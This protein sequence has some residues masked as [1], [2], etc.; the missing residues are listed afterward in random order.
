MKILFM[1]CDE[2]LAP[3]WARVYRPG[4]DPDIAVNRSTFERDAVPEVVA[5]YP[6]LILDHSYFP[7]PIL[8]RCRDLKHIVY[9]GTGVASYVDLAAAERLGIA[10]DTIKGY[11]D[12]A[13]A[14]H[15]VTLM[16]AAA[17]DVTVMDRE[18]RVGKWLP[19][20][21][22]QL[23]GKVLGL[24][25]LGGI[26][27]EVARIAGGIGMEVIG[28]NRTRRD[29]PGLKQVSLD[30]VLARADIL[31][32]NLTLG[33]ET[34]N[35][36]NA[37]RLA[38]TKKGVIIVNTARGALIEEAALLAGLGS[39]HIRHAALDVFHDEPLR[40]TEP[41][42]KLANVTLT[43]HSGF[44]TPDSLNT[45]MRRAI[46]LARDAAQRGK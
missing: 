23:R 34:R 21:G 8:K 5:G 42:T 30:E 14:E 44:S 9:L 24:I 41:L 45:L 37:E 40:G 15:A 32:M 16:M 4:V 29:E 22:V 19:R 2:S 26:G 25:G 1:D 6:V 12:T 3:V 17:R 38:R 10:I 31:S 13:V 33:E 46:D 18:L 27:R 39:G 28:W 43:A 35:F 7:E 20:E 36:L 11:G